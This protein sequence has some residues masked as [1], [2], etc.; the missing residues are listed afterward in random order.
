MYTNLNAKPT[1]TVQKNRRRKMKKELKKK[2]KNEIRENVEKF[3]T[4]ILKE[5]SKSRASEIFNKKFKN[6]YF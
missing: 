6:G 2:K 5:K 4:R 3:I 1:T